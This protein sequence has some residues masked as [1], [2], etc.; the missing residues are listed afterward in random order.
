MSGRTFIFVK[1]VF[2]EDYASFSRTWHI[3]ESVEEFSGHTYGLVRDDL[4]YGGV[5]TVACTE[6]SGKSFFTVPCEFIV[7]QA[8]NKHPECEYVY[9]KT[10]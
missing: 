7:D 2:P 6:D 3:G 4:M 10:N 5:E 9:K 1:T 8:T